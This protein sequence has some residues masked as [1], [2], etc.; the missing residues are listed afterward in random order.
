MIIVE[1]VL[2][3]LAILFSLPLWTITVE[4]LIT[5]FIGQHKRKSELKGSYSYSILMP[6]HN[7]EAIIADTLTK[8][9]SEN[10]LPDKILVVADNCTDKTAIIAR[11]FGVTVIER[12][13]KD[14]RGKGYALDFGI[15]YLKSIDHTDCVIILDA[16]CE[17]N[18]DS[19]EALAIRCNEENRPIQ[20][21]YMMRLGT[22]PTLKQRVAGFAWLVKNKIRP[23]AL[24]YFSFPITLTGTGMAFP[25]QVFEKVNLGHSNIVEDMQLGIDLTIQGNAPGFSKDA[26]VLSDFPSN[27]DAEVTQRTRWE[28]GHLQTILQQVPRLLKESLL[29]LDY[30]LLV[31]ALD[32][33]VP[34]LSFLVV[35]SFLSTLFLLV[36]AFLFHY[37]LPL[38]MLLFSLLAFFIVMIMIWLKFGRQYLTATDF[39]LV[40]RYIASKIII[41]VNFFNNRQGEWIRTSRK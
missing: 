29:K 36:M 10:I 24:D 11:Q 34:P 21:L 15:Q 4:L 27:Q 12:N 38:E 18:K 37:F 5:L 8:W 28:H 35:I 17:I 19:L 41:Y 14:R 22:N 20:A 32:I 1:I 26:L 7:E 31:F 9:L 39:L 13:D 16:D 2:L 3:V 25:F 33:A 30:K 6:A 23:M 40:P